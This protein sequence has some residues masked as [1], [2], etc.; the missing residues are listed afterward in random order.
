MFLRVADDRGDFVDK[1]NLFGDQVVTAFR[2][3]A[4]DIKESGNC[5][6]AECNTAAVFHLMRAAE[7]ALRAIATDRQVSFANK[8]LS[9]QEWGTILGALE[10]VLRQMRLDDAKKWLDP[11]SREAQ[12]QFYNDAVQELRAFN[13]AWRR[14]IS[15]ADIAAFYD[16]DQAASIVNHVRAFM[17]KLA[18][19]ISETK[20]MPLYWDTE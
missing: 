11:A 3:A 10:G 9:Q 16:R 14:Y 2:S 8:P 20:V 17:Q 19:R 15:H 7:V 5:L 6:A 1:D 12:I 13:E 18:T 4:R